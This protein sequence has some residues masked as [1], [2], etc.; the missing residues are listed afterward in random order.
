MNRAE[1]I[2]I[3]SEEKSMYIKS[4]YYTQKFSHQKRYMLWKYLSLFRTAQYYKEEIENTQGVRKLCARILYRLYIRQKNIYGEKCGVE[5]A[6]NCKLGRR[7]DIWHGG[8]VINADLGDDC[9]IRGNNILG[10]KGLIK[11]N[12][13]P[14]LGNGIDMG[15]GAVVIG[16][17][18]IA[19]NCEIGANAMVNKSFAEPGSIIVG[20]PGR[21]LERK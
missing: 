5:I 18:E 1:L 11:S 2:E 15:A 20:I 16:H 7:L 21:V 3:I 17:V 12:G 14:I 19:D 8:V 9:I 6:N 10:N 13:K 4:N